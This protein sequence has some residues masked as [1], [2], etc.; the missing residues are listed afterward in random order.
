MKDGFI[1][2]K[3]NLNLEK[4]KGDGKKYISYSQYSTFQKC[5]LQ[6]KLKNIDKIKEY[7]PSI[8]A[9]FGTAMHNV[10]QKWL[11]VL[12]TE[13]VKK[14]EEMDFSSMLFEELKKA[15]SEDKEKSG[16][17][18]STKEELTEF[19]LDGLEIL[20]FLRKKRLKYFDRKNQE[21]IGIEV[22]LLLAPVSDNPN[23][24][25]NG[26]LDIVLKDKRVKNKFTQEFNEPKYY[27]RDF[28]TSKTGWKDWDKK[29]ATKTDQLLLY[30]IY[31]AQQ[32]TIPIDQIEVEFVILKRK[33][34]PDSMYPQKRVQIFKPSQGSVS[35]KKTLRNFESFITQC[36]TKD[37]QFNT[38]AEYH[39]VSGNRG[40]NC[41]FCEF[42]DRED[43]CPKSNRI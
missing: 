36:F 6:W 23:V 1:L 2:D 20:N 11:T 13:T 25:L 30:K 19:Y 37:G 42:K 15:Y 24:M 39:A 43:L 27:I 4:T 21:L 14:S 8:H 3:F 35:Y 32:Y 18:F 10:V 31:F 40:F 34:D 33:I 5:P 9:V 16:K 17:D 41:T 38:E 29:D 7:E 12:F 28:K 26:F 22:P